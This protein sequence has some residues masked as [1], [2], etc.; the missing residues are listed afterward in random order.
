[1]NLLS[2]L[3]VL[4]QVDAASVEE[5]EASPPATAPAV[6]V[7]NVDRPVVA[8]PPK[9]SPPVSLRFDG[10]YAPRKLFSIPV[11]GADFGFGLGVQPGEHA[12][13]GGSFRGF[14]G[15]TEN[16]LRVWDIRALAE[17]EA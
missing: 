12:A 16:G 2:M 7:E 15:G 5:E 6:V 8:R 17:A 10:A 3:V 4:A 9:P 1:M 11:T 13:F 14:V